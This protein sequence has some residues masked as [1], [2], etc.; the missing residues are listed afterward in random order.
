MRTTLKVCKT[1]G[2]AFIVRK[3]DDGC[4]L[5]K[6]FS[7]WVHDIRKARIFFRT[8][9]AKNCMNFYEDVIEKTP[10]EIIPVKMQLMEGQ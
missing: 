4:Y 10:Y 7:W 1:E 6:K 9:D 2:V 3:T 8:G 5:G